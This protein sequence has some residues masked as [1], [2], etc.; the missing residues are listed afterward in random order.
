MMSILYFLIIFD[1]GKRE[2]QIEKMGENNC[3]IEE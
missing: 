3:C 2:K 1:M